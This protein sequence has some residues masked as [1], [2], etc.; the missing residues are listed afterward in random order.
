MTFLKFTPSRQ[1]G[2]ALVEGP[3]CDSW[4]DFAENLPRG[5]KAINQA[6]ST[7]KGLLYGKTI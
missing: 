4:L 5:R 2:P 3:R 7:R 1:G 6:R